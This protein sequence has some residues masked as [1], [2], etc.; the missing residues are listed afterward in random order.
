[1]L[2]SPR[3]ENRQ[4]GWGSG[5]ELG[6]DWVGVLVRFIQLLVSLFLRC[7]SS[8]LLI[9]TLQGFYLLNPTD[10]LLLFRGFKLKSLSSYSY[11]FRNIAN[12]LREKTAC[13]FEAGSSFLV[14]FILYALVECGEILLFLS[15]SLSASC[16]TPEFSKC[17]V[18]KLA[19]SLGLLSTFPIHYTTHKTVKHFTGFSLPV[20]IASAHA[21][22]HQS[23]PRIIKCHQI[24]KQL[25]IVSSLSPGFSKRRFI[26][27]H[28]PLGNE[29]EHVK[30]PN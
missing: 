3:D 15:F 19:V 26:Q 6:R 25:F 5:I 24:R 17:S 22:L 11:N 2:F 10:S 13:V 29:T 7:D 1:M 18:G 23:M 16:M 21:K 30:M 28:C 20:Y 12:V 4:I 9:E 27:L 14:E 8:G